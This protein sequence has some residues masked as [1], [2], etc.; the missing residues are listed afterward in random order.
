MTPDRLTANERILLW[1]L[2]R[3]CRYY[4]KHKKLSPDGSFFIDD[5][6]L[7]K[8]L[9][10]SLK[11]IMRAKR[12]LQKREMIRLIPGRYKGSATKY[13]ILKTDKMTPFDSKGKTDKMTPSQKT[14][15][16]N[17]SPKPDNLSRKAPQNVTPSKYISR[18]Q[19][20]TA[21]S[22]S[23]CQGQASP[24]TTTEE[25]D[26]MNYYLKS[27]RVISTETELKGLL[28]TK[29]KNEVIAH[30]RS[31]KIKL[32]EDIDLDKVIGQLGIG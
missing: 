20:S 19:A 8:D 12:G 32:A 16:D 14:K 5:A 24:A 17:L 6:F 7:S 15:P 25:T 2:S 29:H 11:T 4:E 31:G 13:W 27:G 3:K 18:I 22:A 9:G 26:M 1:S 30:I 21:G 23:A 10:A 28:V